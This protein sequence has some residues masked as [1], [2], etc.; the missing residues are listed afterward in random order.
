MQRTLKNPEYKRLVALL[1]DARNKAKLTQRD[2][3]ELLNEPNSFVD[4]YERCKRRLDILEFLEICKALK[5]D[6]S[7]FI[8]DFE[9]GK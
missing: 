3:A 8:K 6:A 2:L 5:L 7:K 4:L 1:V 9:R